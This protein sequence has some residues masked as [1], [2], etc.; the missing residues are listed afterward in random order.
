MHRYQHRESRDPVIVGSSQK[1]R[2][3]YHHLVPRHVSGQHRH[4]TGVNLLQNN[5]SLFYAKYCTGR[6]IGAGNYLVLIH[7]E[8]GTRLAN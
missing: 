2:H 5:D 6:R 7:V 8:G 4:C 3:R 1:L